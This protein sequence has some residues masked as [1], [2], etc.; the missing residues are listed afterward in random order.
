MAKDDAVAVVFVV[1]HIIW[2]PIGKALKAIVTVLSPLYT[3]G[4]FLL[5]PVLHLGHTLL[6]MVSFPFSTRGLERIEVSLHTTRVSE[7][8]QCADPVRLPGN[9]RG[10]GLSGW[11]RRLCRLPVAFVQPRRRCDDH[12]LQTT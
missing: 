2:W 1:L 4:S 5:L 9:R 11:R 8:E 7:A 12:S 3:L 6:T 10:G